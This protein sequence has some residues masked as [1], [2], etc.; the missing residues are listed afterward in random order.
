MYILLCAGFKKKQDRNH[1]ILITEIKNQNA[2][3][4]EDSTKKTGKVAF[5]K[6]SKFKLSILK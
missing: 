5:R 4:N 3:L 1:F 6:E 2:I